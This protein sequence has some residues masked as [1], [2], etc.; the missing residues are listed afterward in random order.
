MSFLPRRERP[1]LAGKVS[2]SSSLDRHNNSHPSKMFRF[3]LHW[4][5]KTEEE[6]SQKLL[7][8]K[9][10]GPRKHLGIISKNTRQVLH[11][12][13]ACNVSP[14]YRGMLSKCFLWLSCTIC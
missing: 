11:V 6:K 13:L 5:G 14:L 12:S 8:S 2:I 9:D 7:S 1:L 3:P 4:L 10:A